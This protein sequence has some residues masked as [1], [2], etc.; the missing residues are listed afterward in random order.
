[1]TIVRDAEAVTHVG[2]AL[3]D[4]CRPGW[5]REI[6]LDRLN[7]DSPGDCPLGQLYSEE[8]QTG[9]AP[10]WAGLRAVGVHFASED[11]VRLGFAIRKG[12]CGLEERQQRYAELTKAWRNEIL[13]RREMSYGQEAEVFPDTSVAAIEG[14]SDF[15]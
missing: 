2:A 12:F 9:L 11:A 5:F 3:L 10:Y 13:R 14:C 8:G 15:A 7:I 6:D 1:M 4:E